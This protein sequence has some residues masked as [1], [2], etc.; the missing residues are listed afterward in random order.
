MELRSIV[1]AFQK[2]QYCLLLSFLKTTLRI[3]KKNPHKKEAGVFHILNSSK[4]EDFSGAP[5][6]TA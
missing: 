2:F 6:L 5:N 3:I 4:W 1:E